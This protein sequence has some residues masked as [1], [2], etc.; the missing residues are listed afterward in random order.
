VTLGALTRESRYLERLQSHYGRDQTIGY[1][2]GCYKPSLNVNQNY[3]KNIAKDFAAGGT[4]SLIELG[5][6][7]ITT[8]GTGYK[9]KTDEYREC[10]AKHYTEADVENFRTIARQ[11]A[12]YPDYPLLFVDPSHSYNSHIYA[13]QYIL[14][15]AG[16][17]HTDL[18]DVFPYENHTYE[19]A[20]EINCGTVGKATYRPDLNCTLEHSLEN[21]VE[22]MNL[23]I[24]VPQA[25]S[26]CTTGG[27]QQ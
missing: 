20:L 7:L 5:Q 4:A 1:Y 6:P 3:L 21:P 27:G 13:E 8:S 18:D 10:F 14:V 22:D 12:G 9:N 11:Y 19:E 26:E 25:D 16:I 15:I 23:H 24:D 2:G 17:R